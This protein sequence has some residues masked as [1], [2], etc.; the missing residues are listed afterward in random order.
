VNYPPP[1]SL[2]CEADYRTEYETNYCS[3]PILTF[4]NYPVFFSKGGFDHAF[5]ESS[6]RDGVKDLFSQNRATRMNWIEATLKD[7]NAGLYMGWDNKKKRHNNKSRVAV[8]KGNY[9]VIIRFNGAYTKAFFVTAF[10]ADSPATI[11][12]I[13]NGPEWS[14]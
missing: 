12:K 13:T 9:V 8:V 3:G 4:D 11:T 6:N 10:V 7:R 2:P 5:Y 14:K 1:L